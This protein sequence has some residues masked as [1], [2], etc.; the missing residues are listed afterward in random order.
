MRTASPIRYEA[1]LVTGFAGLIPCLGL[2]GYAV[3]SR[4]LW[5]DLPLVMIVTGFEIILPL[6]AGLS[7]SH[8][9]TLETE[10]GFDE[11]RRSYPEPRRRLPLLRSGAALVLMFLGAALGTITFHL[12]WGPFDIFATLLPSL[13]PA[14]YLTGLSLLIGGLSRSYWAAASTVIG[15]WF[16]ELQTRG[17]ITGALFLF[18]TVWKV[19]NASYL[20][21][22]LLLAGLGL[23]FFAINAVWYA[24]PTIASL[25]RS[26][27]GTR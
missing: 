22:R 2:P 3:L 6:T 15:Y 1:R 17:K 5:A 14:L 27:L 25:R 13:S 9:M 12:L 10:S 23:L 24:Y 11:L 18:D 26:T 4:L 7:A 16:I 21:N 19:D 8:L 20:L